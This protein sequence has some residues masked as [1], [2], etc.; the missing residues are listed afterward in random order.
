[1]AARPNSQLLSQ[2]PAD[3]S[4][5]GLTFDC[6]GVD[7]A[8]PMLIKSG[9][10]RKPVLKKAYVA[11][12]VCFVT[13][14]VHLEL[15]SDLTTAPFIATL[16]KFIGR[17]GIP[18]KMWSDHGTNFIGAERELK[19]LLQGESSNGIADFCTSQGI[20]WIFTPEHAP[21]FGRLWD[22]TVKAFKVHIRKILGEV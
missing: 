7:Y 14:A 16:R 3:R 9:P 6:V 21:H 20:K 4:K 18:S 1:M 2:L 5:P 8:G 17:K 13:K 11:V 19:E 22:T 15:V 12:F 10:I